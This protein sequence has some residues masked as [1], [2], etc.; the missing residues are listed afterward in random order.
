MGIKHAYGDVWD[1]WVRWRGRRGI[2]MTSWKEMVGAMGSEV[3]G[4]ESGTGL[5]QGFMWLTDGVRRKE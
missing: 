2:E 5:V 4:G 1:E 3:E